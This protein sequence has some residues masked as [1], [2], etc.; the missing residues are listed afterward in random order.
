MSSSPH[1]TIVP[2]DFDIEDAF[3]STNILKY[4]PPGNIFHN[5]SEK[6]SSP[7]DTET[8]VGSPISISPSSSVGSSSPVRTTTPPPDYFFDESIFAETFISGNKLG[9]YPDSSSK[10]PPKRTSTSAAPAMTQAAIRQL[11]ADSVAAALE[12]QAA[13]MANT[14]NTNRNSGPRETPAAKKST[15]QIKVWKEVQRL[16]SV[17]MSFNWI[18]IMEELKKLPNNKNIWSIVRKLIFRAAVYYIWIER[19][20][21]IFKKEERDVKVLT[22]CIKDTVQLK[23]VGFKVKDSRAVREVEGRWQIK[24]QRKT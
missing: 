17:N 8:P 23:I 18:E 3:S 14:D 10:M 22:Q 19:N 11:V 24:I 9:G 5:P 7:K 6:I 21:R 13:N 12:A 4:F 16:L 15:Y 2:S 1:S 20:N